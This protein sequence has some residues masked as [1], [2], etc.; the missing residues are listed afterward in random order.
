M[1]GFYFVFWIKSKKEFFSVKE[2]HFKNAERKL[3]EYFGIEKIN[4]RDD[5]ILF[6]RKIKI[7][8]DLGF[9]QYVPVL[10]YT[11]QQITIEDQIYSGD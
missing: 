7:R 4:Q 1:K 2:T 5:P 3:Y 8:S 6:I 10:P 11:G 9:H